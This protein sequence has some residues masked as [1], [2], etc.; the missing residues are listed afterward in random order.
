MVIVD[1]Y[2]PTYKKQSV[3]MYF[4]QFIKFRR[5][6]HFSVLSPFYIVFFFR[7]RNLSISVLETK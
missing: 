4:V 7:R 2:I 5:P 3:S 6:E 1:L